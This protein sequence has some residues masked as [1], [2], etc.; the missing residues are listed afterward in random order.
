MGKIIMNYTFDKEL[1]FK[2][3]TEHTQKKQD[4]KK[5]NNLILK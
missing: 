5:A 3:Y 2:I 4:I 1:I